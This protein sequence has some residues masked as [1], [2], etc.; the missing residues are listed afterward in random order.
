MS[1]AVQLDCRVVTL[2]HYEEA[3]ERMRLL[4]GGLPVTK[5]DDGIRVIE[6]WEA[7]EADEGSAEARMMP[8]A[9]EVGL[10]ARPSVQF[11]EVRTTS[12]VDDGGADR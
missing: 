6:V 8:A 5:T 11:F 9:P 3:I 12:R 7:R 4:P 2:E 10:S 1:V